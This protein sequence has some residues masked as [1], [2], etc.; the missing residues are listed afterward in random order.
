MS[1]DQLINVLVIV[2]LVEMMIAVGLGVRISDLV[3]VARNLGFVVRANVANYVCVPAVAVALLLLFQPTDPMI[4]AGFL[5][6]AVCPGAPFGPPCTQIARGDVTA[7]VGLMVLLAASSAIV[8]PLLLHFLLPFVSGSESLQ[9]DAVKIVTTLLATQII[10]L[11]AGLC[12]RHWRPA[13][14]DKFHKPANVV[15]ASLSLLTVVLILIVHFHLLAEIRVRGYAGM[16]ALLLATWAIGWLLGGP[17]RKTRKAAALTTSLRNVG[18]GL[19]IA[20]GNFAGTAAV[21]AVLA[22]GILEILGTLALAFWW[23]RQVRVTEPGI[24]AK[25]GSSAFR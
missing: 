4:P 23:G 20:A 25:I 2:M 3:G 7:A 12:L 1:S 8:A 14:A 10:P 13:V 9:V 16:S 11:C 17:T 5:I 21:T 18:V 19:V 6:L 24:H 22:Y 15:S